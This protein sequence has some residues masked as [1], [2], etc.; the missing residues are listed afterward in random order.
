MVRLGDKTSHG[1][2]VISASDTFTVR[3]KQVALNGDTTFCPQC[4]GTFP[5]QVAGS[6][7]R[8]HGKLVA[9]NNDKTACGA[10]LVSSI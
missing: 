7:R 1:G 5:I 2:L 10:T 3:G 9:Y 6:E 8:H 4:K